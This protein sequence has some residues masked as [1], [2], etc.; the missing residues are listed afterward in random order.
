MK[1]E[2]LLLL[3][4]FCQ[5]SHRRCACHPYT[6]THTQLAKMEK[7]TRGLAA[8][9][10]VDGSGT[11]D[12]RRAMAAIFSLMDW[13]SNGTIERYDMLRTVSLENSRLDAMVELGLGRLRY[14]L[15]PARWTLLFT[16]M[17]F[18]QDEIDGRTADPVADTQSTTA[19][20]E[21][22]PAPETKAMDFAEA[23]V[24]VDEE[25]PAAAGSATNYVRN[26]KAAAAKAAL[27]VTEETAVTTLAPG[28]PD[29]APLALRSL[30]L[31]A[32]TAPHVKTKKK[33]KKIQGHHVDGGGIRRD[34]FATV[35][36][37]PAA[38]QARWEAYLTRVRL[39]TIAAQAAESTAFVVNEALE[40][41]DPPAARLAR[42]QA[43]VRE[44]SAKRDAMAR[45]AIALVRAAAGEEQPQK[46]DVE[47]NYS[48]GSAIAQLP[49]VD[50]GLA[51]P[52]VSVDGGEEAAEGQQTIAA[53]DA[54]ALAAEQQRLFAEMDITITTRARLLHFLAVARRK[55]EALVEAHAVLRP[56][57]ATN[58]GV[59]GVALHPS[60]VKPLL[61]GPTDAEVTARQ[62]MPLLGWDARVDVE[63]LERLPGFELGQETGNRVL[64]D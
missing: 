4:L 35:L 17:E 59:G 11:E 5:G 36:R 3:P 15:R 13:N 26:K 62:V 7:F 41:V 42:Y 24:L 56:L 52:A 50:L 9:D 10:Q 14:W 28:E 29:T 25:A 30:L 40:L 34:A 49:A 53:D 58:D 33:T 32:D 44:Q 51:A 18:A 16:L 37:D 38:V 45:A 39:R 60:V 22:V 61:H 21:E 54:V 19:A 12:G 48:A 64:E 55:K 1:F 43:M 8:D 20:A 57:L 27:A 2:L 31:P 46:L 63:T 47:K 6:H 23:A